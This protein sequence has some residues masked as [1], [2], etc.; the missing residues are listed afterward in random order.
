METKD[1]ARRIR[2]LYLSAYGRPPSEAEIHRATKFLAREIEQ[3]RT[4]GGALDPQRG[5]SMLCQSL[6]AANEFLTV[7]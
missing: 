6:L 3:Q 1:D 7:K 5:W 4:K 2:Q